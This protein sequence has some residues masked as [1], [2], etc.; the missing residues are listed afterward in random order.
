MYIYRTVLKTGAATP[1][2][3]AEFVRQDTGGVVMRAT[4]F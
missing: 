2:A 3:A 1:E 4:A